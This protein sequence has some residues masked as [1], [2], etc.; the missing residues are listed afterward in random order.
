V[1]SLKLAN[2]LTNIVEI[3]KS[4]PGSKEEVLSLMKAARTL[5]D[6]PA[7]IDRIIK[8]EGY[9]NLNG[10][11]SYCYGLIKE[12][13][14]KGR[15]EEYEQLASSYSEDLIKFIRITGL[16]RKKIFSIYD[17][18]GIKDIDGLKDIFKEISDKDIIKSSGSGKD[19]LTPLFI[20]R[21]RWSLKYYEG[22][23]GKTPRWPAEF[24]A[25]RMIRSLENLKEVKKAQLTGSIRR[26]KSL[27]GDI[28]IL[29]L[30]EFNNDRYDFEKS[31]CL[32][33]DIEK[34]PFIKKL[35][36]IKKENN[37]IS[38]VYGT[39][40]EINTEII[41]AGE[42]TWSWQ[43]FKT[44][45]SR[46]H[47]LKLKEHAKTN[48]MQDLDS[49]C[50]GLDSDEDIYRILG[51]GYIPVELR[52]G[53]DE[54]ELSLKNRLPNLVKMD[55]IKGDLHIH[56]KWSDG[57]IEYSGIMD[58]AKKQNYGY[59]A[60]SD[61]SV[62]NYYGNGLDIERLLKKM[63]FIKELRKDY[64]G[65]EI[66]MGAEI[67]IRKPGVFDY[68]PEIIRKLDIAIA[69]LHSSFTNSVQQNTA[70]AVSALE[71]D[72]FDLFAHPTGHVFGNRAPM[73][74]DM[75]RIIE[76]AVKYGKAL[77]INSYYMRLDLDEEN[78]R[79]ARE[80]G[81]IFAVNTDSHRPGNMEMIQLGVDLA[82]RAGLE[83]KDIIN[84]MTAR[85]LRSWRNDR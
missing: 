43:L 17:C 25:N 27:I 28:D 19:L 11:D 82:R 47:L 41:I 1:I 83:A 34:L 70:R 42:R 29:V 69:S 46:K 16:G 23:I 49:A 45:G 3:K 79:K 2:I 48:R 38:A 78:T 39:I 61:H 36:S 8:G 60:I 74:I 66:L 73:F 18:F 76:A 6:D 50:I 56:S 77:E 81:A 71:K 58:S 4:Y 26:K 10:I 35:I 84:T 7:I 67:D 22:I 15:I 53:R 64:N 9:G 32:L 51:L 40:Y 31:T 52:Q 44:T 55:D 13:L 57:L 85:E 68:P 54:I 62:S 37:D 59:I 20:E 33:K 14:E 5:R 12:Y 21:I 63:S 24:F 30:P 72:Y 75:D 65:I 80:A